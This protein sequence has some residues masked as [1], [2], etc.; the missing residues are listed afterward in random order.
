MKLRDLS[1]AS[2]RKG[3]FKAAQKLFA[4]RPYHDVLLEEVAAA[5]KVAKGTLYLY[6]K[7]KEQLYLALMRE[8]L[9]PL[10]GELKQA[11]GDSPDSWSALGA[12][13]RRLLEFAD[14]HPA[15]REVLRVTTL[16]SR[17]AVLRASHEQIV[18]LIEDVLREGVR[19]E[20]FSE[21]DPE[22]AALM[23][24]GM[25]GKLNSIVCDRKLGRPL[26]EVVRQMLRMV[27]GGLG[28]RIGGVRIGGV[29][30]GRGRSGGGRSERDGDSHGNVKVANPVRAE[31]RFVKGDAR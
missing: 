20:E 1:K 3:I 9:E 7:N 15:L 18:S 4:Q 23:I 31:D 13:I 28:V 27:G 30:I 14:R 11:V 26:D 10:P 24:L 19:Q 21:C 5:A 16:E 25:V 17:E 8:N 22:I 12:I 29:R 6:F 2:K